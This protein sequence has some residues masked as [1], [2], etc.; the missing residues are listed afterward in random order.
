VTPADV[1]TVVE[2]TAADGSIM[3]D[4]Q[5]PESFNLDEC[6]AVA[7]CLLYSYANPT[8]ERLIAAKLNNGFVSMSHEVSPEIREYERLCATVLNAGVGPV[9]IGY[10]ERLLG[11]CNAR[12]IRIMSS[13]GGLIDIEDA[14]RLPLRTVVSGPAA[15]VAATSAL[16]ARMGYESLIAFDMGGTSTDVTLI[17]SGMPSMT[18]LANIAGLPVRLRRVDVHTVGC[19]G[20]SIAYVDP[21]GAL[22]V[23]PESAG[24]APGPALFGGDR[25]TVTDA[26]YILGRMSGSSFGDGVSTHPE[27]CAMVLKSL[28]GSIGLSVEDTAQAIVNAADDAMAAAVR[29]VTV[30]RGFEP[31]TFALVAFGGAGPMHACSVA[32]RL[33]ISE[34]L[35]PAGAGVFSAL[36]LLC[37]ADLW[38]ESL[39]VLG[40]GADWGDTYREL[41]EAASSK[42]PPKRSFKRGASMRYRGQGHELEIEVSGDQT[43][44]ERIFIEHHLRTFDVSFDRPVDWVAARVSAKGGTG[45][46]PIPDASLVRMRARGR[47]GPFII[48]EEDCTILVADGWRVDSLADGTLRLIRSG[49]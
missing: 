49:R 18:S 8:N 36:G 35:V 31:A 41:E 38:E 29:K 19:G 37:A 44:A 25:P 45:E 12:R 21:V 23:G 4:L 2:R 27:N 11:G 7:I 17:E 13:L 46:M 32:E 10:F 16:G 6:A 3:E 28:A 42:V 9:I 14:T 33:G 15:G 47:M 5:L 22:R 26:D 43:D 30:E 39:G 34:I 24:A 20:G 48:N 40:T 1:R